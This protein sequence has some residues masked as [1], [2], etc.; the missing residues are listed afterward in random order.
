MSQPKIK[1]ISKKKVI[2]KVLQMKEDTLE[3]FRSNQRHKLDQ[4]SSDDMDNRHI[5]SKN[6]EILH[7]LKLLNNNVEVLEKEILSLRNIP[8]D[9]EMTNVQFGSLVETDSAIVLVAA[10]TER[11]EI[12][13]VNIVGV[14]TS[15][16]LYKSM[17]G[18]AEGDKFKLNGNEQTVRSLK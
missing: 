3:G 17:E 15:A 4:A 16:P 9:T 7:E 2:D 18:L 6:E 11:V 13:G 1:S 10:P 12:D 8:I 5:D 14:S